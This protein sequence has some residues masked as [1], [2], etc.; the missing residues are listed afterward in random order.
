MK[1]PS[2][3]DRTGGPIHERIPVDDTFERLVCDECGFINYINPKIVVGSVCTWE[4][5][6]L[7]CK[8]SIEPRKGY[9]T[10]PAGYME[11]RETA[12]EG[13]TREALEEACAE[14]SIDSLLGVYSIARISQVQLIYRA[15]L[16]M[17]SIAAGPESEE[18]GLFTWDEIPWGNLAFPSVNWALNHFR[19]VE[20]RSDFA[21]RP[22]GAIDL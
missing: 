14:I 8:R 22:E 3:D 9:W 15:T 6:F 16:V 13:A 21:A 12:I 20:G 17:P 11:E 7:L 4:D 5:K 2:Y 1:T 10:I 18:V 19:E